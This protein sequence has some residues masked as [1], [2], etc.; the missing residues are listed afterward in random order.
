MA[1]HVMRTACET[2]TKKRTLAVAARKACK[3]EVTAACAVAIYER[4][5]DEETGVYVGSTMARFFYIRE[6]VDSLCRDDAD[7]PM[8][9]YIRKACNR[10]NAAFVSLFRYL[11]VIYGC[12]ST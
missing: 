2:G 8:P 11:T 4:D 5:D 12:F 7:M 1:T 10:P 6:S 9:P 3:H